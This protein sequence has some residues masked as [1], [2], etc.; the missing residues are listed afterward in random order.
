[1]VNPDFPTE[2]Y[3]WSYFTGAP[4]AQTQNQSYYYNGSN[5]VTNP[6]S[7]YPNSTQNIPTGSRRAIGQAIGQQYNNNLYNY[8]QAAQQPWCPT[9]QVAQAPQPKQTPVQVVASVPA[10]SYPTQQPV[11]YPTAYPVTGYPTPQQAYSYGVSPAP[12]FDSLYYG[13]PVDWNRKEPSW[14]NQY[15]VEKRAPEVNVDW[16]NIN[17]P[18]RPQEPAYGYGMQNLPVFANI[19][20]SY[21]AQ[22]KRNF[23]V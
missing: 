22:A 4:Q 2:T 14:N 17:T 7:T 16:K 8:G 1:M 23:N 20:E 19:Q 11:A 10:T 21:I 3:G 18:Q 5:T 12:Q 13:T 15:T 6:F 9:P